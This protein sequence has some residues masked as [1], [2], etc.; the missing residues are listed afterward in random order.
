[1]TAIISEI[2]QE[3][4][5]KEQSNI[6]RLINELQIRGQFFKAYSGGQP[7]EITF[8][9]KLALGRVTRTIRTRR[10]ADICITGITGRYTWNHLA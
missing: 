9:M 10:E 8:D 7:Q 1:M 3:L 4:T 2:I 6:N 5:E